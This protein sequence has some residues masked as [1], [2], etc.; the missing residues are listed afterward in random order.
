MERIR[1]QA[2]EGSIG[3]LGKDR[4]KKKEIKPL[5]ENRNIERE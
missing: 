5:W 4:R 1:R 2:L 3:E